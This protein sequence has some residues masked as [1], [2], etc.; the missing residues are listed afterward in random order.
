MRALLVVW[1]LV[2]LATETLGQGV[3]RQTWHDAEKKNLKE[4]FVVKDT[5]RNVRHG[6]YTSYFVNGNI[7][8]KGFFTNNETTGLWEFFYESGNLKMRGALRHNT[9]F[10]H[11]EYFYESGHK[12]MEGTVNG[13]NREG[14]WVMYYENGSVKEAGS[15]KMN[16]RTGIW[17]SFYEDGV[18]KS[19]T[20]YTDDYGRCTE[21]YHSGN[22]SGEGP[23]SGT[24]QVGHWR[25]FA[26]TDGT[27]QSEGDYENGKKQGLWITYYPSGRIASQG[28]YADGEPQG[29]WE[30]YFED[31]SLSAS[32]EYIGGQKNGYWS[33]L[34]KEGKKISEVTYTNGQGEYREFYPNGKLKA[35]G[36]IRDS[37]R[38]GLWKFYY[39]D[40]K[41]EGECQ[42]ENGKGVYRGYYPNGALQTKGELN[43]D[44]RVGT[45]EIYEP[46][47]TLTGYYKPFYDQKKLAAEIVSMSQRKT[48]TAKA[49]RFTYFDERTNE[50]RG[51]I[52][53]GNP[54]FMFA[55]R[56]PLA[57]EFYSQERLGH[58]F[59][60]V[61]IRDPFFSADRDIAPNKLFERGYTMAIRQKFYNPIKAGMWYFGH[62]IRFANIGHFINQEVSGTI[63]T[64]SSSEQRIQYGIVLG[65]RVMQRNNAG[66]FTLDI[67]ISG[68]IGYRNFDNPPGSELYFN[69]VNQ[70]SLART[71]T[72]G[73]NFGNIFSQ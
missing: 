38:D 17:K 16:Q 62:E 69:E 22:V 42:Y 48:S 28:T 13:R 59:E 54:M 72:F 52:I 19:E 5:L 29:T 31:G 46:D 15:Y 53:G 66:G 27:L 3:T 2:V 36:M 45:W 70:K 1:V 56:F 64:F 4:V 7:E 32:G 68:D 9:N 11:W 40:G 49:N 58:E 37:R 12:S 39:D 73:L 57:V 30:Y 60:F 67:F 35:T 55:G 33:S 25:Y 10:G 43:D 23:K 71:L 61:G 34:S 20:E 51:V 65:Y 6:R 21:Y 8:S 63:V 41:K 18:L 50:F 24:K 26:E 47:G 14:D 44:L